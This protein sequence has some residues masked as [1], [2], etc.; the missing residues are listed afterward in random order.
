VV[1]A[2]L[3]GA[4]TYLKKNGYLQAEQADQRRQVWSGMVKQSATNP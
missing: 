2:T 4:S 1:R 3:P